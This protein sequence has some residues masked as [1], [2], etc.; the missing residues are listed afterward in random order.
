V[1]KYNRDRQAS[2]D[3]IMLQRQD[4]LCVPDNLGNGADTGSKYIISIAS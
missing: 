2:H 4:A 3:N 1:K